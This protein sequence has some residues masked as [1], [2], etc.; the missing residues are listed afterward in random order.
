MSGGLKWNPF[1]DL[2]LSGNALYQIDNNG[3]RSRI[4]PL[5]GVS[6]KCS[7]RKVQNQSWCTQ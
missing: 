1:R 2:V 4:V 7:G 3:L 5:V 6:Y